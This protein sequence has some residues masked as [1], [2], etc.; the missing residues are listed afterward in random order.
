M[1][2]LDEDANPQIRGHLDQPR[3]VSAKEHL[4]VMIKIN[5]TSSKSIIKQ[6]TVGADLFRSKFGTICNL[7]LYGVEPRVTLQITMKCL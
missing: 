2:E 3:L 1:L 6:Q 4:L 5:N 7:L